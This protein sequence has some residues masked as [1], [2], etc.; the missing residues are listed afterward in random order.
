MYCQY[1]ST[2]MGH[3]AGQRAA[4]AQVAVRQA[5]QQGTKE[6][7]GGSEQRN[8]WFFQNSAPGSCR[9][10]GMFN[11]NQGGLK[12]SNTTLFH[13]IILCE[14][15]GRVGRYGAAQGAVGR[16]SAPWKISL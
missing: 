9:S 3:N 7:Q 14:I 2:L 8:F 16:T 5:P 4:S 15:Q 11:I 1:P 6:S 13:M 12:P 10:L